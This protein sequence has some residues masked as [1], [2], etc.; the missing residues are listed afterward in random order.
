MTAIR[1]TAVECSGLLCPAERRKL[2][3]CNA[4]HGRRLR[5]GHAR[6]RTAARS[7]FPLASSRAAGR[8]ADACPGSATGALLG[9]PPGLLVL[10]PALRDLRGRDAAPGRRESVRQPALSRD[11]PHL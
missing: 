11:R 4:L 7:V 6:I 9:Q 8:P 10:R 5:L 1:L 2:V 3:L